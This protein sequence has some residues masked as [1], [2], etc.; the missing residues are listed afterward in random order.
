MGGG[1]ITNSDQA[2]ARAMDWVTDAVPVVGTAKR[3]AQNQLG[4]LNQ[5]ATETELA[6][7]LMDPQALGRAF[8]SLP[9]STRQRL[10]RQASAQSQLAA[11]QAAAAKA[12]HEPH[13]HRPGRAA[14]A[15]A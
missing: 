4:K 13:D 6:R 8:A 12:C 1:S 10:L 7:L 2:L 9:E 5:E 3:I 11:G 15:R 14:A